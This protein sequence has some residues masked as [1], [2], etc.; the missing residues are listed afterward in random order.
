MSRM[1]PGTDSQ[2]DPT[3]II[4]L[5]TGLGRTP[6]EVASTFKT[7]GIV[8][9]RHTVRF[10]NPLV[11][12]LRSQLPPDAFDMDVIQRDRVRRTFGDGRKEEVLIPEP[13]RQFLDVFN[14]GGYPDL[15][16]A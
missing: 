4:S 13:V 6:D 5:L 3:T 15:L 8:G 16:E 12:Y 14:N 9:V 11:R 2:M 1:A 10:L 7:H